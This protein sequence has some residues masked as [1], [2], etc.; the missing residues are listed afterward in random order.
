M[1][2]G[3]EIIGTVPRNETCNQSPQTTPTCSLVT[4]FGNQHISV[5][6]ALKSRIVLS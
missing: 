4:H 1:E 6:G 3:G 5:N 2:P